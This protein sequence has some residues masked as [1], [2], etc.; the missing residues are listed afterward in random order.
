[1]NFGIL[2]HPAVTDSFL[3]GAIGV[4]VV[5]KTNSAMELYFAHNTESFV[6]RLVIFDERL[7]SNQMYLT[8]SCL[9]YQQR[10]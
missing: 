1:M 5:K 6:S 9:I 4:M 10:R 8:G 7:T 2:G 3:F